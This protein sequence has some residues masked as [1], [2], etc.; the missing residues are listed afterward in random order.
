MPLIWKERISLPLICQKIVQRRGYSQASHNKWPTSTVDS[1]DTTFYLDVC[2][3]KTSAFIG[4]FGALLKQT[5]KS[6][7]N[8]IVYSA[9][10]TVPLNDWSTQ[11]CVLCFIFQHLKYQSDQMK[12]FLVPLV[13]I[14]SRYE[15][16]NLLISN[17]CSATLNIS[18]IQN[19]SLTVI[20]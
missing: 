6:Y 16:K 11:R 7:L 1:W 13:C 3:T 8:I 5:I 4:A 20:H 10:P 15:S 12:Q 19:Q 9:Q 2:A 14:L 17:A 18:S